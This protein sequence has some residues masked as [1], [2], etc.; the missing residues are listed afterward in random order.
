MHV[1]HKRLFDWL[2]RACPGARL[3]GPYS[4]AGRN[5]YQWMVRGKALRER[6]APLLDRLPFEEIDEHSY[7]RFL[8]MRRRYMF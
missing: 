7:G 3:Y 5:F 1:R 4:Y 6:V 2:M 8:E